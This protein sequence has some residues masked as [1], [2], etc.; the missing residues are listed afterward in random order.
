M[1]LFLGLISFW[2]FLLQPRGGGKDSPPLVTTSKIFPK[3]PFVGVISEFLKNPNEMMKRCYADYGQ[4]F[5][6]PVSKRV[7][8]RRVLYRTVFWSRLGARVSLFWQCLL[9]RTVV[10]NDYKLTLLCCCHYYQIFHQ[11]MTFLIGP[12]AQELFFKANDDTLS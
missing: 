11:R 1:L 4:V 3:L 9:G 8:W 12:E 10:Y 7:E 6:I 2:W 5:T